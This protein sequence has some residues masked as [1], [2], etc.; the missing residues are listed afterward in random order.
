M[1]CSG[2]FLIE[3]CEELPMVLRHGQAQ[4]ICHTINAQVFAIATPYLFVCYA[5]DKPLSKGKTNVC[6]IEALVQLAGCS[7]VMSLS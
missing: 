1:P 2:I 5:A 4:V 7:H 6:L 3:T